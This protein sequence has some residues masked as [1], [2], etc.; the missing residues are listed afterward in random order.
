MKMCMVC[1][2]QTEKTTKPVFSDNFTSWNLLA[3]GDGLCD[4]CQEVTHDQRY[5]KSNW[6]L[7]NGKVEF[8][9]RDSMLEI[10]KRT[11]KAPFII[12][13]TE[14]FKKQ[15]F[16]NIMS[17]PNYNN[18]KFIVGF[19]YDLIKVDTSKISEFESTA[20]EAREKKFSKTE[21]LTEPKT[22]HWE[23]EELCKKI[24]T[25]KR[26]QLWRLV[27]FAI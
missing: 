19:D 14:T 23:F 11:K 12:Y 13:L 26:D 4:V 8:F 3:D 9:K 24:K 21:L 1:K 20:R 22:H 16:F 25:Y 27:V 18:D 5:R 2:Q 7:E 15:G 17:R 10:L 6:I